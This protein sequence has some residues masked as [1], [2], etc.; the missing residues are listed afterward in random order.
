MKDS[1][2][3]NSEVTRDKSESS[4]PKK[5]YKKPE[6]VSEKLNAYGAACNGSSTGGRKSSTS[7]PSFCNSRKL[8][9]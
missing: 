3:A 9:S 7:S 5:P 1:N 6:I 2:K 8:N 4:S